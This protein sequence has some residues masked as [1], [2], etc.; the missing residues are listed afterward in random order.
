VA[1]IT[2]GTRDDGVKPKESNELLARWLE[3][4]SGEG[5]GIGELVIE[6]SPL[7]EGEVMGVLSR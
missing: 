7:V 2:V 5:T 1:H 6:G 4:G 3:Q